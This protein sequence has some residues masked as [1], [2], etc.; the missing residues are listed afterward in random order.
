[1]AGW[2]FVFS[3]A[4]FPGQATPLAHLNNTFTS[5]A[6]PTASP[7]G[8]TVVLLELPPVQ[9]VDTRLRSA[10]VQSF[11]PLTAVPPTTQTNQ[12]EAVRMR[13]LFLLKVYTS[14]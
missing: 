9:G 7:V 6:V 3:C 12:R 4:R 5:P 1:M 8:Y 2:Y 11:G 10:R 14:P 13:F